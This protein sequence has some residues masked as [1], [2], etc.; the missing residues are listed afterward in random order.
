MGKYKVS[1]ITYTGVN[2]DLK[3]IDADTFAELKYDGS[4]YN[5]HIKK[6][7]MI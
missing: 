2:N 1:Q 3:G 4:L 7:N 6:Y 5:L